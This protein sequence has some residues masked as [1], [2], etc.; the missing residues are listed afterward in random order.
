MVIMMV[1]EDDLE[2]ASVEVLSELES[3]EAPTCDDDAGE[4]RLG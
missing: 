3:C 2:E 4:C 1:N